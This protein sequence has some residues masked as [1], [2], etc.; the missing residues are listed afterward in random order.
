M[1]FP[2]W[3]TALVL[4]CC[5]G[6]ASCPRWMFPA[7]GA[8]QVWLLQ[9]KGAGQHHC[10]AAFPHRLGS[11]EDEDVS[12]P[13][14]ELMWSF[15]VRNGQRG[16]RTAVLYSGVWPCATQSLG[17]PLENKTCCCVRQPRL[18][19]RGSP[20]PWVTGPG[21]AG[22]GALLTVAQEPP[23]L[24]RTPAAP[25]GNPQPA[26]APPCLCQG[27][28]HPGS[29][30]VLTHNGDRHRNQAVPPLLPG[31]WGSHSLFQCPFLLFSL[32]QS[33]CTGAV[34]ICSWEEKA[35]MR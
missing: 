31:L 7:P 30:G 15:A 21:R 26:P 9:G 28:P 16:T 35:G 1:W 11:G 12:S 29:W 5:M 10:C 14:R 27:L 4:L 34:S 22:A 23:A 19:S 18:P 25:G 20:P 3:I 17:Y 24:A 33:L 32:V 13:V 2:L 8:C 6:V